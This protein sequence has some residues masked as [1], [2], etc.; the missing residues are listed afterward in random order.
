[1]ALCNSADMTQASEGVYS[2]SIPVNI[3][4]WDGMGWDGAKGRTIVK[5]CSR[6]QGKLPVL[7]VAVN[8]GAASPPT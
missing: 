1:M 4:R 3:S 7:V 6:R 5:K 2:R 8:G